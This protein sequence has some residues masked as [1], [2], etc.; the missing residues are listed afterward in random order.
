MGV[1]FNSIEMVKGLRMACT[2]WWWI[3]GEREKVVKEGRVLRAGD[4]IDP[5]GGAY[6]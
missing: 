2:V 1:R 5:F 3:R 4:F 6:S